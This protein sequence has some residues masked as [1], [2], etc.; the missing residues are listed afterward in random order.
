MFQH[1]DNISKVLVLDLDAHQ[2]SCSC[3][4][5]DVSSAPLLREMG[6]RDLGMDSKVFIADIYNHWIYPNDRE[7]K[8]ECC[9]ASVCSIRVFCVVFGI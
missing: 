4:Y 1:L 2:V 3:D 7:A 6:M 9:S 8:S 5:R